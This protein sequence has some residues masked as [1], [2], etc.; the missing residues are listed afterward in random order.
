MTKTHVTLDILNDL[1]YA[2]KEWNNPRYKREGHT[3]NWFLQQ[4]TVHIPHA[5]L[6][7]LN[8]K[9]I[10][11]QYGLGCTSS[12]CPCHYFLYMYLLFTSF[13]LL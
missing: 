8:N 4:N 13:F 2:S 3:A 12:K 7:A 10:L 5:A 11:A 6:L 9:H 1:A